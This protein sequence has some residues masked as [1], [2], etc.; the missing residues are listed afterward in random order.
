ML[1]SQTEWTSPC[2]VSAKLLGAASSCYLY[3]QCLVQLVTGSAWHNSSCITPRT[4]G[5]LQGVLTWQQKAA[6]P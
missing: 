6:H 5:S 3:I 4:R 2:P 1:C